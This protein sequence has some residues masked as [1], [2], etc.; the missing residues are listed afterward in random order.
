LKPPVNRFSSQ[1]MDHPEE[2]DQF[3]ALVR[4][5]RRIPSRRAP[6]EVRVTDL[7]LD[8]DTVSILFKPAH[9]LYR[10]AYRITAGNRL[11]INFM[12]AELSLWPVRNNWGAE[13]RVLLKNSWRFI[14]RFSPAKQRAGTGL[15]FLPGAFGRAVRWGQPIS[16]LQRVPANVE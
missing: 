3:I 11:V 15:T 16:G 6:F 9:P 13:R 2:A 12:L 1:D 4:S 8:T 5:L 14:P 7:L 10:E